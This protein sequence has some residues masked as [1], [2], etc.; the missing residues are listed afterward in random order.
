MEGAFIPLLY[1]QMLSQVWQHLTKK[2]LDL[3]FPIIRAK[4]EN[5]AIELANNS[6][7][8]LGAAVFT[9]NILKGE[10]IAKNRLD[11]GLCFVNDF[12]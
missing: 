6:S 5:N 12:V 7:F 4:N 10:D 1:F 11:A 2:Y 9:K 8:G 3:F